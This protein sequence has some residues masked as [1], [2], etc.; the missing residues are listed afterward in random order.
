MTWSLVAKVEYMVVGKVVKLV[1][2]VG[3]LVFLGGKEE[4]EG[5]MEV[6]LLLEMEGRKVEK[7]VEMVVELE[8]GW[9]AK[10]KAWLLFLGCHGSLA[11]VG[12]EG[13]EKMEEREGVGELYKG[14]V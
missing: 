1:V 2:E 14:K 12:E 13:R 6:L 9:P 10:E 11:A 8:G 5:G 3:S 4:E 7:L